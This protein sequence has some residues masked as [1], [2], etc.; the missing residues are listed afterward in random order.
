MSKEQLETAQQSADFTEFRVGP[1]PLYTTRTDGDVILAEANE[2]WAFW[3]ALFPSLTNDLCGKNMWGAFSRQIV[4]QPHIIYFDNLRDLDERALNKTKGFRKVIQSARD[5]F[6]LWMWCGLWNYVLYWGTMSW[7]IYKIWYP[8]VPD[9]A[10]S[11]PQEELQL[12]FH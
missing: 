1:Y 10:V 3:E 12:D 5:C 6:L 11:Q 9:W 8:H 4:L 7:T 2:L